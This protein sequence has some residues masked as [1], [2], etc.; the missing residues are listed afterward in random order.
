MPKSE[1]DSTRQPWSLWTNLLTESRVAGP[2]MM[3]HFNF[4]MVLIVWSFVVAVLWVAIA[5][6]DD[7]RFDRLPD[8]MILG[9][10][11]FGMPRENCILVAWGYETQQRQMWI[12]VAF[13]AVLYVGTFGLAIFH[14]IRQLRLFEAMDR[15]NTTMT[16][17]VVMVSGLPPFSGSDKPEETIR[18]KIEEVTKEDVVGVSVAWDFLDEEE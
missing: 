18:K 16:D 2:G 7:P 1:T 14:S 13:L 6:A 8:L 5:F 11:K 4:Q 3:L 9:T 12:K 10:R 15:D 17:F